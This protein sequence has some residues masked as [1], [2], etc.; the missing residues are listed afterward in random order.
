[1]G[2][3][4]GLTMVI[5]MT[6]SAAFNSVMA[7]TIEYNEKCKHVD[8]IHESIKPIEDWCNNVESQFN[9]LNL[10]IDDELSH[11]TEILKVIKQKIR[12][13]KVRQKK[14]LHKE[15]IIGAVLSSLVSMLLMIKMF[16]RQ[17]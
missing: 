8:E 4:L 13:D 3:P 9:Q 7:G 10:A 12:A 17:I 15:E 6:A 1:M 16:S 5:G 11:L 14:L 2:D